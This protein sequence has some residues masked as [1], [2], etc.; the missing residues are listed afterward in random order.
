MISRI[1]F[2]NAVDDPTGSFSTTLRP[3]SSPL[4]SIKRHP[5]HTSSSSLLVYFS[6][7]AQFAV[8]S[9][10]L[11]F[12]AP[13]FQEGNKDLVVTHVGRGEDSLDAVGIAEVVPLFGPFVKVHREKSIKLAIVLVNIWEVSLL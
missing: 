5:L 8:S 1:V 12:V 10:I 3:F 6:A 9:T 7:H 11:I 13:K 2:S 4:A